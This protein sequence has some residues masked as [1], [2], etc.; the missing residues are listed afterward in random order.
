LK[1]RNDEPALTKIGFRVTKDERKQIER[2][3]KKAGETV[4]NYCRLWSLAEE[5]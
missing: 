5:E 4:A 3:A 1:R 2:L